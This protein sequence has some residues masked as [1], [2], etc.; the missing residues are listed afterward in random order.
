M[1]FGYTFMFED[2]FTIMLGVAGFIVVMYSQI[3]VSSTYSKYK[4]VKCKRDINGA[5]A[6]RL[7]LEANGLSNIYVVE[8]KGDL[9]DHYDPNRKVVKLS[10]DIFHGNSIASISV[11]AHECGH[12]IQD[13]EGYTFMRIR[14]MMIPIVNFVSYAGYFVLLVSIIASA[15]DY[16]LIG[17]LLVISS[18]AFQVITLPVEIDAS[19]RALKELENIDI[20]D[21]KEIIESKNM[22]D[23]AALTY[24]ASVISSLLS[25]LRLLLMFNK[26][27]D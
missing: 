12:A 11:A 24:V 10:T 19:K 6:A 26:R 14:S 4:K 5:E 22:L 25:L 9:M 27:R 7:I 21:K 15:F 18:L 17:I 8:I 3:K 16:L 1:P 20:A 23:A 2:I 13:K